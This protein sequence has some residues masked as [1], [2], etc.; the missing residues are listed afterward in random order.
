MTF[1]TEIFPLLWL[2][3]SLAL[4]WSCIHY[5]G[6]TVASWSE[7]GAY[8][9]VLAI[10]V[11]VIVTQFTGFFGWLRPS[12]LLAGVTIITALLGWLA[13]LAVP[14]PAT[15]ATGLSIANGQFET[16]SD[17][18]LSR[19]HIVVAV[20]AVLITTILASWSIVFGLFSIPQNWDTISYHL[21]FVDNWLI[22]QNIYTPSL[23]KWFFPANAEILNL[24]FAMT[25][26]TNAP[27]PLANLVAAA[28]ILLSG[29][30]VLRHAGFN[31]VV[32]ILAV[33][34]SLLNPVVFVH[35]ASCKND[36]LCAGLLLTSLLA[37]ARYRNHRKSID[38]AMFGLTIGLAVGSKFYCFGYVAVIGFSHSLLMLHVRS[39][40]TIIR[41][42]TAA[43]I[44]SVLF[45][46]IWYLRNLW[47]TGAPFYPSGVLALPSASLPRAEHLFQ[48]SLFG[49][50]VTNRFIVWLDA[51]WRMI[52]SATPFAVIGL[53]MFLL[54]LQSLRRF[55]SAG[56]VPNGFQVLEFRWL[57]ALVILGSSVIYGITPF[58]VGVTSDNAAFLL[59]G[60]VAVR[61][62]W[63]W[64]TICLLV[65]LASLFQHYSEQANELVNTLGTSALIVWMVM[66]ADY[67]YHFEEVRSLLDGFFLSP[68]IAWFPTVLGVATLLIPW[69]V[70][71]AR[72]G[73]LSQSLRIGLVIGTGICLIIATSQA[74]QRFENGAANTYDRLFGTR[75][76]T[77]LPQL[78][79]SSSLGGTP[80]WICALTARNQPLAGSTRKRLVASAHDICAIPVRFETTGE[81][82]AYLSRFPF[83]H[84]VVNDKDDN[85]RNAFLRA[86]RQQPKL[87]VPIWTD[88]TFT[89]Y[90]LPR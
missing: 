87:A 82:L 61:L 47:L 7:R 65:G 66:Q 28:L 19:Q 49:S 43:A 48:T 67:R 60:F 26:P 59:N 6:S 45:S 75:L 46:G 77:E 62:G 23:T 10:A 54:S 42:A 38:L 81:L 9:F 35:L 2:A 55:N 30:S 11:I 22:T 5:F 36:M 78:E 32:G 39:P 89:V 70:L 18:E 12:V 1:E 68:A 84:L 58:V 90:S 73:R 24:W 16:S 25:Q 69:V 29:F 15:D 34:V 63:F 41:S 8:S 4:I 33:S 3:A 13:K 14:D 79:N 52:G 80:V 37:I 53:F 44:G 83:T 50:T 57:L 72:P 86:L 88:G 21:L 31:P 56:P 74:S 17:G 85:T 27:A 64:F 76:F 51:V 71:Y 20:I 40:Q